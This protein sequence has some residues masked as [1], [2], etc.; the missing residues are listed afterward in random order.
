[1]ICKNRKTNDMGFA[2]GGVCGIFL[3]SIVTLKEIKLHNPHDLEVLMVGGT[4]KGSKRKVIVVAV[5]IP[6]NYAV[7]RGWQAQELAAGAVA[8]AKRRYDDPI[9]IVAGDFNQWRIEEKLADFPDL[10]EHSIGLTRGQHCIDRVFSNMEA[11]VSGNL[12]PLETDTTPGEEVKKSDHKIAFVQAAIE[13]VPAYEM[14]DYQYRFYNEESELLYGS[15][16]SKQDWHEVTSAT[17]S[18]PKADAYQELVVGALERF[19]PLVTV[20]RKS[21]D[22][23][24]FNWKVRKRESTGEKGGPLSGGE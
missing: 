21:T 4:V 12:P 7:G 9:V 1:M 15:W 22:P 18:N 23:P 14:L 13:K 11:D 19:F 8:E 3:E 2:H 10:A 17:G 20:R 24:W 16:L 6:P 5:Y